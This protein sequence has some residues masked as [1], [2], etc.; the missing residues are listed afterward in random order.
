[1]RVADPS[2][3]HAEEQDVVLLRARLVAE[4]AVK[5]HPRQVV[6]VLR[7]E[8]FDLLLR[9][10]V[11]GSRAFLIPADAAL[12]ALIRSVLVAVL[13]GP[14]R[15]GAGRRSASSRRVCR[16]PLVTQIVP[17]HVFFVF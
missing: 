10:A 6:E 17:G 11:V 16:D 14:L 5:A 3:R 15:V 9:E 1:M 8:R 4:R 7:V 2:C 12:L 13:L